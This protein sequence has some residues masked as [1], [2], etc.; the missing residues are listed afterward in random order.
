[1]NKIFYFQIKLLYTM[2]FYFLNLLE[3]VFIERNVKTT[4]TDNFKIVLT[5]K[6]YYRVLY[7]NVQKVFYNML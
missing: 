2:S 1:M 3:V 4:V 6:M 5:S 7:K